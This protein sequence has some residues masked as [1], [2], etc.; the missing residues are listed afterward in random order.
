MVFE[1]KAQSTKVGPP[2]Q[3]PKIILLC[4]WAWGDHLVYSFYCGQGKIYLTLGF[5]SI[6]PV[7]SHMLARHIATRYLVARG[8]GALPG[9][10]AALDP[11]PPPP[12]LSVPLP[13]LSL[14]ARAARALARPRDG[15]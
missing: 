12:S 15:G 1:Y 10:A 9:R 5:R 13:D 4:C 7:S 8:G 2:F 3:V 11:N 14:S 6:S